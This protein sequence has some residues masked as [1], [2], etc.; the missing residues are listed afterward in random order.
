MPA[1]ARKLHISLE[2]RLKK[3]SEYADLISIND[4]ILN[5]TESGKTGIVASG[6]AVQY[7]KELFPEASFLK[8]GMDFPFPK[9]MAQ[10]LSEHC[11]KIIVCEELEPIIEEQFNLLGISVTGKNKIPVCGELNQEILAN[12]L[13]IDISQNKISFKTPLPSRPPVLCPG[14]SHRPLFLALKKL[15]LTVTGDIGCYTL[16]ALPP[17]DSMDTCICMGASITQCLGFELAKGPDFSKKS[18]AVIGDSTFLHSGITGLLD[19]IYNNAHST[20][21][22]LDNNI[23]A[24]TGHQDNAATGK[25]LMK[26]TAPAVNIENI[27]KALGVK[28]VE[29]I[30]PYDPEKNIKLI[31]ECLDFNGPAVIIAK[32]PCMLIKQHKQTPAL[33]VV[34]ERCKQCGACIRTGC[35]AVSRSSEG[36][37]V[38]NPL[39]CAGEVCALCSTVCKFGA[40]K[41][42]DEKI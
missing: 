20:V 39:M 25:T 23:T 13:N 7:A 27:C 1:N 6:I 18:V 32:A 19:V 9:K 14:C 2:E 11:N 41:R 38:I 35:P 3:I 31:K 17:L 26:K 34:P 10:K 21:I 8:I 33:E 36:Y 15:K 12:S 28:K 42:P 16:G 37:A 40:H 29:T 30:R 24:M 5:N 4:L 22:I